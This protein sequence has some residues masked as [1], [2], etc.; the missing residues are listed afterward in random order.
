MVGP[1][2]TLQ[3]ARHVSGGVAQKIRLTRPLFS[4]TT[5]PCGSSAS[6]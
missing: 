2:A 1:A 3:I 6:R 4:R 5:A